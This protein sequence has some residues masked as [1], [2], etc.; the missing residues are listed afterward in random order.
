M[1]GFYGK[2]DEHKK[3]LA[4]V[5]AKKWYE[6][7]KELTIKRAAKWKANNPDRV[8]EI[9]AHEGRALRSTPEGKCIVFMRDSLRRCMKNK[10]DRTAHIL[11]YTKKELVSH[12]ERQFAKGMSWEN[13][14]KWHIDHILPVSWHVKNGTTDPRIINGLTNLRP[15]WARDN[16]SKGSKREVLL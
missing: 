5:R 12:I 4:K 9:S 10:T 16:N 3:A 6:K 15:M 11:G 14:G 13:H 2:S 1:K 8:K 7:N